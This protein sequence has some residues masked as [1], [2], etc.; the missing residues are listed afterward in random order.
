MR[1]ASGLV[2]VALLA[3]PAPPLQSIGAVPP[4]L[5]GEF[6]EAAGYALR[7][8]GSALVF[9]R[10]RHRVYTIDAQQTRVQPLVEIGQ[11]V[12]RVLQPT[13]FDVA[14]SGDF[15]VADA[16]GRRP[17]VSV[18]DASGGA[19]STFE[20]AGDGTPRVALERLVLGGIASA[21]YTGTTVLV[22][23]PERGWLVTEYTVTGRVHREFGALRASGF[24][25]DRALHLAF[26]TALAVP[27]RDG[28]TFVVFLAGLP[29]FRR[30]N[31][32]G[33]LEYERAIQGR[34]LDPVVLAMPTVWPRRTV[35]DQYIPLVTPTVR[36]AA[37][38][39]KGRL[40]VALST[41]RVYV[42]GADGEKTR[43]I[44][45]SGAGVLTPTSLWFS[46]DGRL[47]VTPGLYHFRP[48]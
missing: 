43:D 31:A 14:D 44:Q 8:D 42:Y 4:H 3:A 46:R 10:R 7:P 19:L 24:E 32:R 47:L 27:A 2:A 16:P 33:E 30:Y 34:D 12:G 13:A 28:G 35:D 48:D 21:R 17:R 45:L 36:T 38:D 41:S 20:V 25:H 39:R 9:D 1:L 6:E 5:A 11:E 26:N 40:W 15:I 18:F 23:Q 37:V 29:A 22:S